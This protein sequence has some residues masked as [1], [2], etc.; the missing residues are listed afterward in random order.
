[1]NTEQWADR[2]V[3]LTYDEAQRSLRCTPAQNRALKAMHAYTMHV[4]QVD[5]S[6]S[7]DELQAVVEIG[8]ALVRAGRP[9]TGEFLQQVL[10]AEAALDGMS[11]PLRAPQVGRE[12]SVELD[13]GEVLYGTVDD[14]FEDGTGYVLG[15]HDEMVEALEVSHWRYID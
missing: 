15:P 14:H 6:W 1:M 12:I 11:G 4:N 7:E 2:A 8:K 10:R 13:T 5:G 9:A 3:R